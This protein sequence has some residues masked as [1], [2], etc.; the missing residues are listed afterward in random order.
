MLLREECLSKTRRVYDSILIDIVKSLNLK[1]INLLL[2]L[3]IMN[4]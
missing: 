3:F 1:D 4:W 2:Y